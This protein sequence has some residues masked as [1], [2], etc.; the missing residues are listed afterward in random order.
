MAKLKVN[1]CVRLFLQAIAVFVGLAGLFFS[2]YMPIVMI[3]NT[4]RQISSGELYSWGIFFSFVG[5]GAIFLIGAYLVFVSY[6][7]LFKFSA[8]AIGHLCAVLALS[9]LGLLSHFTLP[10]LK[11]HS[12]TSFL[13]ALYGLAIALAPFFLVVGFYRI[14]KKVF[15]K[16]TGVQLQNDSA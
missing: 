16:L 3:I 14:G 8:D 12:D 6:L 5:F 10:L 13:G 2:G 11:D 9:S 7:T 15:V 4:V 1:D